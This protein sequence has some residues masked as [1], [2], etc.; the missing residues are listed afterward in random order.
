MTIPE[1]KHFS[2]EGFDN[3]RVDLNDIRKVYFH[4]LYERSVTLSDGTERTYKAYIPQNAHYG[5]DSTY[6]AVPDGVDTARFLAES[7]WLDEAEKEDNS[8]ILFAFEPAD[9]AWGDAKTELEYVTKAFDDMNN[10]T[11]G[12]FR[13]LV[14]ISDFN[15]RWAGYGKGGEMV[16]RYLLKNPMMAASAA[17]CSDLKGI[18]AEELNAAGNITFTNSKGYTYTEWPNKKI[19]LPMWLM[20]CEN[21]AVTEYWKAANEC[22]GETIE[23]ADGMLYLQNPQSSNL[24]T[25]D[26]KEGRVMIT[27]AASAEKMNAFITQFSRCGM[28]SPY[29]NMLY[30]RTPDSFF[31]RDTVISDDMERE[32]YI[33]VPASYDPA[34][35]MPMVI[36]FHGH[37]QG[38]LIAMR[39]GGWW[40]YGEEKGFITVCPSGCLQ[41]SSKN[42]L[43]LIAWYTGM[44][45]IKGGVNTDR[46]WNNDENR[47]IEYRFISAMLEKLYSQYNIDKTRMYITGQSNGCAMT[48][49]MS[50]MM[51]DVFTAAASTGMPQ[52]IA[53]TPMPDFIMGGEYDLSP[54][55]L[56]EENGMDPVEI[57]E[58]FSDALADKGI[59]Y[60]DGGR[61]RNGIFDNMEW[62]DAEGKPVYRFCCVLGQ[63]HSWRQNVCKMFWDEWFCRYSRDPETG[64][65]L[66][67]GK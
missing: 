57:Q 37:G 64:K 6:V 49:M 60:G 12:G 14:F 23:L 39:Q 17:I 19:P 31:T 35:P 59:A 45:N 38:G 36:Y 33:H 50:E 58:R 30:P 25:F 15:W 43:P 3:S 66:Y 53:R 10:K 21:E 26:Q 42:E 65:I 18:T 40:Q 27:S 13:N 56:T 24:M 20:N 55:T 61:F 2:A 4:G 63:A 5:D 48:Q 52:L 62:Q 29:G 46:M 22:T 1:V 8:Y 41:V 28:N 44:F 9:K 7:G 54:V 51:S 47:W 32:W 34:K 67:M 11:G 16:M